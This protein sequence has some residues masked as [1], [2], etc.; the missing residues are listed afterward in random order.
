MKKNIFTAILLSL[1]IFTFAKSSFNGFAGASLDIVP[2]TPKGIELKANGLFYG[3]YNLNKNF[4]INGHFIVQTEDITKFGLFKDT[5]ALFS[6][7]ELSATYRFY[8]TSMSQQASVFIGNFE[9][10]GADSFVKKYFGTTNFASPILTINNG[11]ST[12]GMF[13]FSGLGLSYSIKLEKPIAFGLYGYFDKKGSLNNINTDLRFAAAF[14]YLVIDFDFGISL[15]IEKKDDN[16]NDVFALIRRVDF[17]GGMSLLLGNNPITNLFMQVGIL[18]LQGKPFPDTKVVSLS[19]LY[20]Y[21]EPRFSTEFLKCNIAFFCLPEQI[22]PE[23]KFINKPLGVNLTLQTQP[24]SIFSKVGEI[25]CHVTADTSL[26]FANFNIK[27][28]EFQVS[29]F[30]TFNTNGG[31]LDITALFYPLLYKNL[32]KFMSFSI[33]YKTYLW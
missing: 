7:E 24:M 9:S 2:K 14:E 5:E 23:L 27:N 13:D 20:I 31:T 4:N 33:G 22:L 10:F 30:I 29:P 12:V 19:D 21:M 28:L 6:I 18:K 26:D 3:Q 8:S 15:P 32:S 25:G 11:T 16:G 17:H 1:C